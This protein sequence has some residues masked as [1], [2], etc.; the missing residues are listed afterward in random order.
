MK[1]YLTLVYFKIILGKDKNCL[2]N[3][4]VDLIEGDF[5]SQVI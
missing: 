5:D 1:T 4:V 3:D 2:N